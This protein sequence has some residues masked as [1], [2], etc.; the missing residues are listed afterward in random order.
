M[1]TSEETRESSRHMEFADVPFHLSADQG[2]HV[3]AQLLGVTTRNSK[4][5]GYL[6][7]S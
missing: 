2:I 3:P 5:T 7:V 6:P 1:W 4:A